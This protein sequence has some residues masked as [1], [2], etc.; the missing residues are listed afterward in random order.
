ME[1]QLDKIKVIGDNG[2]EYPYDVILTYHNDSLDKDYMIITN[3]QKG[4]DNKTQFIIS[5]YNENDDKIELNQVTNPEELKVAYGLLNNAKKISQCKIG[6]ERYLGVINNHLQIIKDSLN[7]NSEGE[8]ELFDLSLNEL[9]TIRNNINL[10]AN[11]DVKNYLSEM[12]DNLVAQ[13]FDNRIVDKSRLHNLQESVLNFIN[14]LNQVRDFSNNFSL[15]IQYQE[16]LKAYNK[17]LRQL[18]VLEN[19]Y[20]V[21][22]IS[23]EEYFKYYN[24]VARTYRYLMVLKDQVAK[25]IV[26]NDF[27]LTSPIKPLI[28]LQKAQNLS[29]TDLLEEKQKYNSMVDYYNQSQM[30]KD[31]LNVLNAFYQV[32]QYETW[33]KGANQSIEEKNDNDDYLKKYEEHYYD[34]NTKFDNFTQKF[35]A[36]LKAIPKLATYEEMHDAF[37]EKLAE[38]DEAL[39][40]YREIYQKYWQLAQDYQDGKI[41]YQEYADYMEYAVKKLDNLKLMARTLN[42]TR[43]KIIPSKK[44]LI[45]TRKYLQNRLK[46]KWNK[47]FNKGNNSKLESQIKEIDALIERR[48]NMVI[49]KPKDLF[50]VARNQKQNNAN[51]VKD[52]QFFHNPFEEQNNHVATDIKIVSFVRNAVGMK[53]KVIKDTEVEKEME[54]P[55][56]IDPYQNI[57]HPQM[58]E[59]VQAKLNN[60]QNPTTEELNDAML[61]YYY[62]ILEL[63]NQEEEKQFQR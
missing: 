35:V 4:E 51:Q 57:A 48:N 36:E 53:T 63:V 62:H 47:L 33:L 24:Y 38:Y 31:P 19:K 13:V 10:I 28:L 25:E 43:M 17:L 41:N 2:H 59:Y 42:R 54:K 16:E 21:D 7:I 8:L 32:K 15:I 39:N 44:E 5:Y 1:K 14:N 34:L 22:I 12:F 9:N 49:R 27:N 52:V 61:E 40:D 6:D 26:N 3:W 50:F 56:S 18:K 37:D 29:R 20:K 58:R 23:Y 60:K 30:D 46:S 45:N 11:N 55:K